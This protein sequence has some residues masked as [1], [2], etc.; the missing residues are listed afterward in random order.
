MLKLSLRLLRHRPGTS[1]ATLVAL[2]AGVMILMTLSVFIVSA[3]VYK[4]DPGRY[5]AADVVVAHR[6]IKIVTKEFDGENSTTTVPLPE[7]TVPTALGEQL[8]A[9]PGVTGV[10]V[11]PGPSPDRVAAFGVQTRSIHAVERLAKENGVEAYAGDDRGFADRSEAGDARSLLLE[12]GS[13]FGGYVVLLIIFVVTGTIGLAVR[14]RRRDLALLRAIAATPR[15]VRRL[16]MAESAVLALAA[17]V[18]GVPAALVATNWVHDQLVGRG[19]V[20]DGFPITGQPLAAAAATLLVLLVAV[21]AARIAARRVSGI[22]PAEALGDIAVE[23][24]RGGKVR[25]VAGLLMLGS[26]VAATVFAVGA[27][28]LA[29]Q[30]SAVGMLYVFVIAVALLA[31]WIN[32]LAARVLAPV[33]RTAW[34]VSGDLAVANL[35][36]NARGMSAVLTALV[37]AVGFGGSVWFLQDNLQ[38]QTVTQSRDGL[39]ADYALLGSLPADAAA[40]IRRMPGVE[41]ATGVRTT[42]VVVPIFDGAEPATAKAVDANDLTSTMDPGVREGNLAELRGNSVAL[43]RIRAD[44]SGWKLGDDAKMWLPDGRQVTLRVVAIYD[45]GLGIADAL[46]PR[47]L[48]AGPDDQVLVRGEAVRLPGA[49][50]VPASELTGQLSRDL[51]IG[52]WLNKLLIGVMVGYA[53]LAAGNTMVMAALARKRE[54]AVLQLTGVTRRQVR[55]MVNAEQVGLLGAALTIGGVIAAITLTA[56]VHAVTGHAVP[57]VPPM[58]WLAVLGGTTALAVITTIVPVRRL[59]RVP[60]VHN[61]GIKE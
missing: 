50:L 10:Q 8:R 41:A 59:L 25:L 60:A 7:G 20:P 48:V 37:L 1:A 16:V 9:L 39:T 44:S 61:A 22:R 18:A 36:A 54:L 28:G 19:F 17:A 14:H 26:G 43:S 33:L 3:A 31:P 12:A 21:I 4:P 49:T 6:Q 15:Q 27:S 58:G 2:A 32:A 46:L 34:G 23:P 56:V 57:Y 38:R 5:A 24:P 45:R 11:F 13:A 35:R 53:A 55:R 51:A 30:A 47:P 52:A 29:A 42:S 40:G